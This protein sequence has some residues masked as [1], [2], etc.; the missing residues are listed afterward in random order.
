MKQIHGNRERKKENERKRETK[1]EKTE[2]Y[3]GRERERE[4]TGDELHGD[5]R[6]SFPGPFREICEGESEL[7]DA[8]E[9]GKKRQRC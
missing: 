2:R 5:S 1:R 7:L 4:K 3:T 8:R 6:L 9:M